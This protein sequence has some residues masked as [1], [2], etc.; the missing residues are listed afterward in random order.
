M[1]EGLT[2]VTRSTLTD[3]RKTDKVYIDRHKTHLKSDQTILNEEIGQQND[4]RV[5]LGHMQII[6]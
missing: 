5:M 3:V 2:S 1:Y 6:L 4:L